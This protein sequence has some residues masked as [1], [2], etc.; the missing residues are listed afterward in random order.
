MRRKTK[1]VATLGP[2]VDS[3]QG[4][5]ELIEAGLNVARFNFSHGDHDG[6]RRRFTWVKETAEELGLPIATLQDIQGPKIRVGTFP[7]GGV[8]LETNSTVSL[9]AGEGEG[10]AQTLH[11]A[12][13][14]S[15]DLEP[16]ARILCSDGVIALEVVA[17]GSHRAEAR[18]IQGG[19]LLDH[20]GAAFPGSPST[21]P[22]ITAKDEEDLRFGQELG[23]DFVA[24]SFI[25]SAEDIRTIR[26]YVGE[27]SII[28]KIESE[29]GYRNLDD[30]LTVAD[31][32]MVARGDL[33]VEL[34]LE[35]I[36]RA[37]SEILNKANSAGKISITATEMLESMISSPRPTRA[38]VTDVYRSVLEDTDAVMLSAETAVGD[39]PVRAVIAMD[40]ICRE[41]EVSPDFGRDPGASN[42]ADRAPFAS[43]VAQA[44]VDTSNRLGVDTIVAF[45]ETGSTARLLSKYRPRAD[46]YAYTAHERTYRRMALYGGITPL[47]SPP[48]HSTDDMLKFSE[49]D[50][51]ER[52][53]VSQGEAVIMVAGTPPNIRATTNLMKVHRVGATTEGL[54]EH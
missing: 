25:S 31:G 8:E 52:G 17:V 39:Y 38:E 43:A 13:L 41:A 47:P 5:R 29:L 54:P 46:V 11:V 16:G 44:S 24:A 15:V 48:H 3:E 26:P 51:M 34:S 32:V 22:V 33:G 19:E 49:E 4:I 40:V 35:S 36:P 7:G 12:Y 10:D 1:I 42:L 20:K 28:A 23:F 6:H 53:I 14:D 37:Q 2:A 30:I 9:V 50:L 45:T 18:V 21:V 27:A